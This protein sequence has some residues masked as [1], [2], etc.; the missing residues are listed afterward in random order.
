MDGGKVIVL[1]H[2]RLQGRV[3]RVGHGVQ[4]GLDA[5]HREVGVV[6]V[7]ELGAVRPGQ[8]GQKCHQPQQEWKE[9]GF[10]HFS[11]VVIDG[12]AFKAEEI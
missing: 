4:A 9:G 6:A 5:R 3:E 12:S 1:V 7:A 11:F 2:H 8:I 10:F